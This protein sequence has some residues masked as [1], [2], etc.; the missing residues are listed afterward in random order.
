MSTADTKDLRALSV[1]T[2]HVPDLPRF[3]RF[4]TAAEL[5]AGAMGTVFRARDESLGRDVAIKALQGDDPGVRER[6]LR[7]ARAIGAVHHPNILAI[8]DAGSEGP[9][10]YI[11]MELATGG[12]LWDRIKG[13]RVPADVVRQVGIQ[14]AQALGAAHA[15]GILHRDVKPAN[16]LATAPGVWKLA[17]FG[18]ARMPDSKLTAAGQFLGSPSYAAPEA[19]AAGQSSPASDVYSL[20]VTLYEALAGMPPHGDHDM[21]SLMKKLSEDPPPV[22]TRV[23][24]P[25][26]LG[27]AIMAALARD[28]ARRPSAEQLAHML[29]ATEAAGAAVGP[30]AAVAA[31]LPRRSSSRKQ[32]LVIAALAA[33]LFGII[34]WRARGDRSSPAA[35]AQTTTPA[36]ETQAQEPDGEDNRPDEREPVLVDQDGNPLDEETARQVMD[37]MRRGRG[38]GKKHRGD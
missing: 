23:A 34:I 14:M 33:L 7:E 37:Q 18:I 31:P 35:Q 12:S 24:V 36:A 17:D 27:D 38:H 21:R 30:V 10:P 3:G 5:G 2:Q 19:L 26:P 8:Y 20:G 15:A 1:D 16:I 11:V 6:F 4:Q 9:I 28:P 25:G 22:Q 29:A 32:K 13:G